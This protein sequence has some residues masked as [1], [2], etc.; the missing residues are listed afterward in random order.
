MGA[1][2]YWDPQSL[3]R[4][5]YF[6]IFPGNQY[7]SDASS[8]TMTALLISEMELKLSTFASESERLSA[9]FLFP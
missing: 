9:D 2:A 6:I 5:F 3:S 8:T 4:P 7:V 1:S